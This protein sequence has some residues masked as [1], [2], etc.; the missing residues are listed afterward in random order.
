MEKNT[1]SKTQDAMELICLSALQPDHLDPMLTQCVQMA[2]ANSKSDVNVEQVVAEIKE[3]MLSQDFLLKH[4][5]AFLKIFSHEEIQFLLKYYKSEA[6]K[7]LYNSTTETFLPIYTAMQELVTN[8][9][10]I[11]QTHDKIVSL[12]EQNYL[13]EIK[14]YEGS[15]LIDVYAPFCAPCLTLGR[16]FDEISDEFSGKVKFLKL[17]LSSETNLA[18]EL[19]IHS[20]PTLLFV[21]DGKVID[22]HVGMI[23]KADL[24]KKIKEKLL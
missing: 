21:K 18:K 2:I 24:E 6:L 20:V 11:G 22:R 8:A 4:S 9:I 16:I 10:P 3:K 19:Q 15:A 12:T 17:N 1:D 14:D 5:E 23:H 13:T 7:K